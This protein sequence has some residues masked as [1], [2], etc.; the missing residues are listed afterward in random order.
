MD[1][2]CSEPNS[3]A[4]TDRYPLLMEQMESHNDRQHIIDMTR[5]NGASSS[6]SH[7][8]QRP[9]MDIPQY[10]D[11]PSSNTQD[12]TH[13]TSSSSSNILNSRNSTFTRRSDSYSHRHRSPLNSGLWISVELL[14]TVG[15]IIASIVVLLMS[16]NENP[17]TPLFAWV[18]GYAS[19]CVATLPF[20]YWRFRNRNQSAQQ[21][22]VQYHQ[23]ASQSTAPESTSYRAISIS[24]TSD[25]ENLRTTESATVNSQIAGRLRVR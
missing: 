14:V 7:D 8:G 16:R 4:E 11:R 22:S 10:D 24:Q 1:V 25:E 17:Q 5:N 3:N 6:A 23:G 19:G 15:Q 12:L 18:L 20:L 13:Q 2:T 21:D 9:E